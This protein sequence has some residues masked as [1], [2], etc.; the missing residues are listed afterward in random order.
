MAFSD[1]ILRIKSQG[2]LASL[3]A[4]IQM[5]ARMYK[6]IS[7]LA[8]EMD[9]FSM[10]MKRVDMGMVNYADAAAKGQVATDSLMRGLAR[11]NQAQLT[12]TERQF[13]TVAVA[14]TNMAKATG[15]DATDAFERLTNSIAKGQS[16][17]LK[18]YGID[19]ENTE[20]QLLA[21]KEAIEKLTK[22]YGD[23]NVELETAS[24]RLYALKNNLGTA[25][26]AIWSVTDAIIPLND[27]LDAANDGISEF[28]KL[29]TESPTAA[30]RFIF[31]TQGAMNI[32]QEF[33]ISFLKTLESIFEAIGIDAP[34]GVTFQRSA[35]EEL[36]R[37]RSAEFYAEM[38]EEAENRKMAS[39][40]DA[41]VRENFKRKIG[42]R[43]QTGR[44]GGAGDAGDANYDIAMDPG[45]FAWA[46][47]NGYVMETNE[48]IL[49]AQAAYEAMFSRPEGMA[50]VSP[51]TAG[52]DIRSAPDLGPGGDAS[53]PFEGS[54]PSEL[55]ARLTEELG[56]ADQR[57][58]EIREAA[59]TSF[60]ERALQRRVQME[61]YADEEMIQA[62]L[63]ALREEDYIRTQEE[64]IIRM[65]QREE[66]LD[67][68]ERFGEVWKRALD[69]MS[70]GT[71][72][73]ESAMSALRQMWGATVRYA[74]EG[75]GSL[76]K[77][78]LSI[79]KNV[80]I[81][82]AAEA[83]WRAMLEIGHALA[84]LAKPF[85]SGS[86]EAA[87]HFAAA[88]QYGITAGAAGLAAAG[89]HAGM[90]GYNSSG[91]GGAGADTGAAAGAAGG[92]MYP[93][94]QQSSSGGQAVDVH[95]T[96]SEEAGSIGLHAIVLE[97][98]K[99]NRNSGGEHIAGA[100]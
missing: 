88:A 73:A 76:K 92:S 91:S 95:I 87:G 29:L 89:A 85:G 75:G 56:L 51:I 96:M 30:N 10:T 31:S 78:L 48:D 49:E 72:A 2:D 28:N 70:A 66:S 81:S 22:M 24:E 83:S 52:Y 38:N 71:Y 61:M 82:I 34:T 37:I 93:A 99:R 45:A 68:A 63:Q 77:S 32:L 7:A 100:A 26:G 47:M 3:Q 12:L 58:Q 20:N 35:I 97:Q 46:Q 14:A 86:G 64:S 1:V 15:Q 6:A 4:G 43:S 98:D 65:F 39:A 23:S 33:G 21:Q 25:A 18:A 8:V 90:G 50:S 5:V 79:V 41:A 13:K 40:F 44:G 19:L 27:A 60:E 54:D 80:G 11:I 36:S 69:G 9:K 17:A 67:F 42:A 53:L 16:R 74:I 94:H 62:R 59:A 55:M 84:A 57:L